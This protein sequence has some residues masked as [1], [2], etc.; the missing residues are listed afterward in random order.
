MVVVVGAAAGDV[1]FATKGVRFKVV[2]RLRGQNRV[3][4]ITAGN[5]VRDG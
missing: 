4:C 3:A 2:G 5:A 1:I